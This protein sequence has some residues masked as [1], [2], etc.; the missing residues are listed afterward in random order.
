MSARAA[1]ILI[2]DDEP[3]IGRFVRAN[4]AARGYEVEVAGDGETAL[5]AAA[6]RPPDLVLLDLMLPGIDGIEVLRRLRGWTEAPIV[7]LSARGED[8]IKVEAL[9]TGADDYLTKPFSVEELL[10]RVRASLRRSSLRAASQL[11]EPVVRA[12]NLTIDLARQRVERAGQEIHLTPTELAL[13]LTLAR[14][15]DRVVTHGMLLREV[16]G[17]GYGQETQYLHVHIGNLR[18]KLGEDP[19]NP[20][21]IITEPGTGYRLRTSADTA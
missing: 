2:V 5:E 6:L 15:A 14:H 10:A 21:A 17:R 11:A 18:R 9:D 3:G 8:H 16:W 1:R 7:V 13:V 12:D 20:R 19:A 4:L